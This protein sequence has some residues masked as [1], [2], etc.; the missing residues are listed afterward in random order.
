MQAA[1][2]PPDGTGSVGGLRACTRA[3]PV[4]LESPVTTG[5]SAHVG[6]VARAP[7]AVACPFRRR[8]EQ[9]GRQPRTAPRSATV[10]GHR[11]DS[12][13]RCP[14]YHRLA[15]GAG[16]KGALA[17]RQHGAT[18]ACTRLLATA[19]SQPVRR[20]QSRHR[21]DATSPDALGSSENRLVRGQHLAQPVARIANKLARSV[22]HAANFV[23]TSRVLVAPGVDLTETEL[24]VW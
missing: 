22:L 14:E 21:R 11:S 8:C 5:R 23:F 10:A 7:P 12:H 24:C 16:P 3:S 4:A 15:A 20:E 18:P 2:K 9:R 17:R 19:G 6:G 1:R 13:R